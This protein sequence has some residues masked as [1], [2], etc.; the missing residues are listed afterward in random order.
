MKFLS[1]WYFWYFFQKNGSFYIFSFSSPSPWRA[2]QVDGLPRPLHNSESG[3]YCCRKATDDL[4]DFACQNVFVDSNFD[5]EIE[6][7]SIQVASIYI[8]M[9]WNCS[10]YLNSS[11]KSTNKWRFDLLKT[12]KK[13]EKNERIEKNDNFKLNFTFKNIFLHDFYILDSIERTAKLK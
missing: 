2:N 11:S 1:F 12:C 5:C 13:I 9:H 6:F 7:W 4:H 8:K 3:E 10:E